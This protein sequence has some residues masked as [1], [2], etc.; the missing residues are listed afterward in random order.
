[1]VV[2]LLV[3]KKNNDSST[4]T[5][6][7]IDDS[8]KRDFYLAVLDDAINNLH[9]KATKGRIRDAK[10]EKLKVDMYRALFYGVN[11]ANA[12]YRDKQIDKMADDFEKLKKGLLIKDTDNISG[13]GAVEITDAELNELI[14]FDERIK[15]L[16]DKD[17]AVGGE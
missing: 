4:L 16:K 13:N 3:K 8:N 2:M 5:A 12:V 7:I 14:D 1:M 9:Y 15:K 6:E 10:K 11:V 17:A